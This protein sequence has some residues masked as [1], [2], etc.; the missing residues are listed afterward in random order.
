MK[1]G[2]WTLVP[3]LPTRYGRRV[4]FFVQLRSDASVSSPVMT[5]LALLCIYKGHS[6]AIGNQF[7]PLYVHLL[8]PLLELETKRISSHIPDIISQYFRV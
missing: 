1:A 7:L 6:Q 2:N 4:S 5:L 8:R 3:S